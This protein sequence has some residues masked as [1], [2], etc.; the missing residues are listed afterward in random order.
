MKAILLY[1]LFVFVHF[2]YCLAQQASKQL[3]VID[4]LQTELLKAKNPISQFKLQMKLGVAKNI[5]R[6]S[7]WDSI[8][9]LADSLQLKEEGCLSL[10]RVGELYA[11]HNK[12]RALYYY[13]KSLKLSTL[14]HYKQQE[15][16]II[17]NISYFYFEYLHNI[18][19]SL[20][21]GYRGLNRA[22]LLGDS[23]A[24]IDFKLLIARVYYF[25]GD[26]KKALK[27]HRDLLKT[28]QNTKNPQ[29]TVS[30]LCD[31]GSDYLNLKDTVNASYY[32]LMTAK[33][34]SGLGK[35]KDAAEMHKAV[36]TVFEM[37]NQFDKA[38]PYYLKAFKIYEYLK[39][40]RGK[41]SVLMLLATNSFHLGKYVIARKQVHEA[42]DL[43]KANRFYTQMPNLATLLYQI[44]LKENNYK[45]A[46]EAYQM[47][48][49]QKDSL[50]NEKNR[51]L[52]L[53]KQFEYEFER[54]ENRNKLLAQQYKT[55]ELSSKQKQNKLI[56]TSCLLS[57]VLVI[58]YLVIRQ[59]KF[60]IEQKSIVLEQRILLLQ[61]NPHFI[62]NSLQAIQN[63]LLQ[64]D[65]K[66]AI[67]YLSSFASV[68][69]SVLENSRVEEITL[70]KEIILL[71]NYLQLQRLRFKNRF[72]YE[73]KLDETIEV[74]NIFVSPMLLQPFIENAIEH[75]FPSVINEGMLIINYELKNNYLIMEVID[76]GVGIESKA[77]KSKNHQSFAISITKERIDIINKK[78]KV[79]STFV[80]SEAFPK[81]AVR[82]GVKVS[83]TIPV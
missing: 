29:A 75:G 17:K 77:T 30:I 40:E 63:Y 83:F 57:L 36:G 23:S 74:E 39:N 43:C 73:I 42:I 44:Y 21:I 41:A 4:S 70:K 78:S 79:K 3:H 2:S 50:S 10:N 81:E 48:V 14:H 8:A 47:Y 65:G 71:Q 45:G 22:E 68:M 58:T 55:Y 16:R 18:D 6:I 27:G 49:I 28:I 66:D 35:T 13:K 80:I 33:Y 60:K 26:F 32:Y 64:H 82:K 1:F 24:I 53:Q 7:F 69:R 61:M 25:S 15:I 72:D 12:A 20:A 54:S 9:H 62:F 46:L 19:S 51:Q 52:T 5:N 34:E 37:R 31:I 38:K 59:S 76:N 11:F 56:F 67:K